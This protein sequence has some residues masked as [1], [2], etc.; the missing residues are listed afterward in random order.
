MMTMPSARGLFHKAII[1]SASSLLRMATPEAAA[2]NTHHF[3]AQLGIGPRNVA[4]LLEV[5]AATLL[6]AMPKAVAAAGSVD[7][8]RPTLDGRSLSVHPFDPVAP[9]ISADIPLMIGSCETEM[10]FPYS[11]AMQNFSYTEEQVLERIKGFVRVDDTRAKALMDLYR[12]SRPNATPGDLWVIIS[13]DHQYRRNGIKASE[14]KAAQGKAPSWHYLFTWKTPVL[15]GLLKSPHTIC[16][17]FSFG[18]VD[19]ASGMVGTGADRYTLQEKMMDAWHAFMR[20]GNPN[21]TG[22]PQWKPY[23][24]NDHPTMIF[25]N[26]CRLMNDPAREERLAIMACPPYSA[27][28][29]GRS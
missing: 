3:L 19:I 16:I 28:G 9:A 27:D 10:T 23:D 11:Q 4:A 15:N 6:Q 2:R 20:T 17:P 22:L 14:L 25:D 12:K 24:V 29:S 8:Y 18:N 7:N 21:H 5:P 1:Q 26:A 13:S